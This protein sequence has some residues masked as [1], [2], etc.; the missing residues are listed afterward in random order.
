VSRALDELHQRTEPEQLSLEI[1]RCDMLHRICRRL[2]SNA[3]RSALMARQPFPSQAD[4]MRR[5]GNRR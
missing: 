1:A 5:C 4:E 2:S 3:A